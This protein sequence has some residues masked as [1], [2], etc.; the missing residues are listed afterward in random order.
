MQNE[1]K[2]RL[3]DAKNNIRDDSNSPLDKNQGINKVNKS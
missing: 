2:L 3:N 1:K